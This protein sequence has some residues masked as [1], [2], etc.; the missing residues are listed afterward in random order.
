MPLFSSKNCNRLDGM[1]HGNNENCLH[2]R[3]QCTL[4]CENN[5]YIWVRQA[6]Q[7]LRKTLCQQTRHSYLITAH[8]LWWKILDSEQLRSHISKGI[9]HVR[10]ARILESLHRRDSL[11]SAGKTLW[12]L[13]WRLREYPPFPQNLISSFQSSYPCLIVGAVSCFAL[14]SSPLALTRS[15]PPPCAQASHPS[16]QCSCRCHAPPHW[17]CQVHW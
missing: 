14:P 17:Q 12:W 5:L 6:A 4:W 3:W 7:V 10:W 11:Q 1:Q 8:I 13:L 16:Y 2:W 15:L 9:R